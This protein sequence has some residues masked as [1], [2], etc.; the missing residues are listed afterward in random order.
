MKNGVET[1][2]LGVFVKA[3]VPGRVKTRLAATIGSANAVRV[4]QAM[5]ADVLEE[6]H[7]VPGVRLR[8]FYSP[9]SGF[10]A[11]LA[12]LEEALGMSGPVEGLL[13]PQVDDDDLGCRMRVALEA[14]LESSSRAVLVG[15]DLPTLTSGRILAAYEGLEERD[16]VIGRATDGGYYLVGV[17][18]SFPRLFEDVPWSSSAVLSTSLQRCREAGLTFALLP[19]ERDVDSAD[20]LSAL[21]SSLRERESG[22]LAPRT[23]VICSQLFPRA[24]RD[25]ESHR[26]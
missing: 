23:R 10:A 13:E 21:A 22:G 18:G 5:A 1:G 4:Y 11:C 14:M 6:M 7:R 3:P 8:V 16:V 9:S 2:E 19:E 15:T 25:H 24:N 17:R 12:L 26:P 20:D